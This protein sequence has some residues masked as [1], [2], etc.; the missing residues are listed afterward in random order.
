M[1]DPTYV[2]IA[3]DRY[4]LTSTIIN[5]L[6]ALLDHKI[7]NDGVIHQAPPA[8]TWNG[9]LLGYTVWWWAS[10]DGSLGGSNVG[11]EFATVRGQ[12]TKYTIE[13]LEHYTRFVLF[14]NSLDLSTYYLTAGK[15]SVVVLPFCLALI[16]LWQNGS[17]TKNTNLVYTK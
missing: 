14:F 2:V 5:D 4:C 13:G 12:V 3:T 7:K 15:K 10:A 16:T 6:Q 9:E 11:M 1:K 17:T 8:A